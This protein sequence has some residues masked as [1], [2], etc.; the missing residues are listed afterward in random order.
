MGLARGVEMGSS[1]SDSSS[2]SSAALYLRRGGLGDRNGE[3]G[4]PLLPPPPPPPFLFSCKSKWSLDWAVVGFGGVTSCTCCCCCSDSTD[5]F[6]TGEEYLP[7]SN[8]VSMAMNKSSP[9]ST[10]TRSSP[11]ISLPSSLSLLP[12][13]SGEDKSSISLSSLSSSPSDSSWNSE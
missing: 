13:F 7:L 1:T 8:S 9:L 6:T 12:L 3:T 11:S 5:I 10:S 2:V 4:V